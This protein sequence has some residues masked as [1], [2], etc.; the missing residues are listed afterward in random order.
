[1]LLRADQLI[2]HLGRGVQPLYTLHGDEP[3]LMQEAADAIRAAA[4]AAGCTERDVFNVSGAHFDWSSVLGAAQEMSLFASAKV[5]E[6]GIP[7]GKP[8]KDGAD[9]L[10]RYA[11]RLPEGV[12]TLVTLPRLDGSQTK[13]AWFSALDAAGVQIRVEPVPRAALPAWIAQRLAAQGQR[14]HD[15]EDGQRALAFFADRVEGNLLAA[16]QEMHKLALLHAAGE[17]SADEIEAAVLNVARYDV[18]Q[19]C[20]A[21]LA[22]Q[23]ARALRMLDGLR[24]EGESAVGVLWQVA[25]DLRAIKRVRAALDAGRPMPLALTDARVWGP[26]QRTIERAMPRFSERAA[27]RLLVAA[28]LCDGIT[29]GLRRPDWPPE[30]WDALRRLVLMTLRFSAPAPARERG[31]PRPPLALIG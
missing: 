18:R 27:Q 4:R 23:V 3:L 20:E 26:R 25:D 31:A 5:V 11:A 15:G 2:A 17:L 21:T 16:Q 28:S 24:A 13:S 1:M 22:G 29:K 6:I 10:Q 12:V 30:P 7:S 8:G 19:L 14:V 9:A